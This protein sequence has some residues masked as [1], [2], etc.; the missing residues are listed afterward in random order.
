MVAF[1]YQFW[2]Q[3]H[4]EFIAELPLKNPQWVEAVNGSGTFEARVV[5]P[6]DQAIQ[7]QIRVATSLDNT[8]L[9]M[10]DNG[11][12]PWSGF[13]TKR[14]WDPT[15]NELVLTAQEWRTWLYRFIVG[16]FDNDPDSNVQE[17]TN[18]DQTLIARQLVSEQTGDFYGEGAPYVAA[19][20]FGLSG[21]KRD[22][23][24]NGNVFQSLGAWVDSMA[25]RDRGF[26]WDIVADEDFFGASLVFRT[27][28]PER[29]S[30]VEGL[31]F[32]Y[33]V[34]GNIVS[35][36]SPEETSDE[37]VRRQWAIGEGATSEYQPYARDDDPDLAND[38][39]LLFD[40]ATS[41]SGVQDDLVLASH[42]R[43]ER[44]FYN[45]TLSLFTF[46]VSMNA[47]HA[48]TYAK[49]DRCGLI[50]KDRWLDLSYEQV[51]IIQ[52]DVFPDSQQMK[53][54]VDLSDDKL[55]EVD[56]DGAV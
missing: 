51:R 34:T 29:G 33:G 42:A 48:Y 2:D 1:T 3:L 25:N 46:T 22:L 50:V 41:W 13:I 30:V 45:R 7:G 53:I 19:P 39:V 9:V 20:D 18:I 52:R 47:P 15:S 6:D 31:T 35:Y 49:G 27:F 16:P 38:A 24:V 36:E 14:V 55:P 54:T 11:V 23:L 40:K 28:F 21:V 8:L 5:I 43:A 26:E 17:W 12:Q 44:E 37:L 4:E 56:V 32:S 10:A